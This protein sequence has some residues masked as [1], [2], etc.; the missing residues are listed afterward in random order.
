MDNTCPS[1]GYTRTFC[2][3]GRKRNTSGDI[4]KFQ[5][6]EDYTS[7]NDNYAMT[8]KFKRPLDKFEKK[9]LKA[10]NPVNGEA[11][12]T[13]IERSDLSANEVCTYGH[14]QHLWMTKKGE[15]ACH[16]TSMN[17]FI[18]T[19]IQH[20]QNLRI[21]T[22]ALH[23]KTDISKLHWDITIDEHGNRQFTIE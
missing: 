4:Q 19:M 6:Y 22:Q 14:A 1:C 17:C 7:D 16:R 10:L 9:Y 21:T 23:Q 5:N 8:A 11:I 13:W 12:P 15:W 2:I 20:I 3:C 18:C